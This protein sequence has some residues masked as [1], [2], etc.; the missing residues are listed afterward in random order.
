MTL[1]QFLPS[2]P[3]DIQVHVVEV[4]LVFGGVIVKAPEKTTL[5][6]F[7]PLETEVKSQ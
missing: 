5:I 3:E 4:P 2:D 1:D 7:E 6:T